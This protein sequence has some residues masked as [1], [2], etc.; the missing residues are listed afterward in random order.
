[1]VL[2]VSVTLLQGVYLDRDRTFAEEAERRGIV[3][4]ESVRRWL[5][6]REESLTRGSPYPSLPE[7]M[8]RQRILTREQRGSV[9]SALLITWMD[10]VRTTLTPIGKAGDSRSEE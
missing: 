5:A 10:R 6:L 9:E 7:W 3:P 4:A 2:A 8:V 1:D